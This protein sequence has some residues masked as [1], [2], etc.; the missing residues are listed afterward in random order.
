MVHTV[1]VYARGYC[2]LD[3]ALRLLAEGVP[4]VDR[5]DV[6]VPDQPGQLL[7]ERKPTLL[8]FLLRGYRRSHL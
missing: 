2:V 1:N 3:R 7:D 5:P 6:A 8:R 4:S